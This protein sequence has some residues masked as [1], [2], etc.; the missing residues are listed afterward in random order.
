MFEDPALPTGAIK[1]YY[2]YG[3][4]TFAAPTAGL[5][6]P[7]DTNNYHALDSWV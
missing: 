5:G 1:I 6:A 4:G 2:G 3:D 7:V